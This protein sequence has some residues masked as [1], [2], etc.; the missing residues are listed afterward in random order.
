MD[1]EQFLINHQSPDKPTTRMYQA[2]LRRMIGEV[3]FVAATDDSRPV[4]TGVLT[5][6]SGDLVT[7]AAAD[8]YRLSVR[9]ARLLDRGD[10]AMEVTLPATSLSAVALTRARARGA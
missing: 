9:H 2:T 1:A 6:F 8:P 10:P 7:M 5:T 4:L 3:A